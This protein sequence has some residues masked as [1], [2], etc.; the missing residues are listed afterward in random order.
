[1]SRRAQPRY[2]TKLL[3]FLVVMTAV[4]AVCTTVVDFIWLG[5]VVVDDKFENSVRYVELRD[6]KG[7]W[8]EVSNLAFSV[9]SWTSLIWFIGTLAFFAVFGWSW[10]AYGHLSKDIDE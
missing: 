9:S 1:M 8:V 6:N 10:I 5:G 3:K 7:V 2:M 4:A